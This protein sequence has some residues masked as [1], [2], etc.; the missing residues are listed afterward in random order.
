[1]ITSRTY[2]DRLETIANVRKAGINVCSGGILGL[3]ESQ[4]VC[5]PHHPLFC[6]VD[7]LTGVK[8]DD[9]RVPC[10]VG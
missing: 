6:N 4:M 9:H 5:A 1:M 8:S 2:D 7:T 3:G 10:R